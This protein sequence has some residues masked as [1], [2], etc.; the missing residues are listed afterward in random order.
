MVKLPVATVQVG[1]VTGLNIG[2]FK[3][4]TITVAEAVKDRLQVPLLTFVK[5]KVAFA[6]TADTVTLT[7]PP[8]PTVAVPAEAP[9]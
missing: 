8:A 7:V 4:V 6:V 2:A 1:C 9:V 5:F 3:A